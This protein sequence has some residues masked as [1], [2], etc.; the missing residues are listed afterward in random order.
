MVAEFQIVCERRYLMNLHPYYSQIYANQEE[1]AGRPPPAPPSVLRPTA[2]SL[3][4]AKSRRSS[5][6]LDRHDD[7]YHPP[8][9]LWN[10]MFS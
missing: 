5:H 9:S 3:L 2:T 6:D 8:P 1:E 10:I 7:K 4:S